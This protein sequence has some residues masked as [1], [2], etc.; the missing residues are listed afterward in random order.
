MVVQLLVRLLVL[1]LFELLLVDVVGGSRASEEINLLILSGNDSLFLQG[2]HRNFVE[3]G[4][5]A[6]ESFFAR[7]NRHHREVAAEFDDEL[8]LEV[9]VV[10]VEFGD[11]GKDLAE[12]FCSEVTSKPVL[13]LLLKGPESASLATTSKVV[14]TI[15]KGSLHLAQRLMIHRHLSV[16]R[17]LS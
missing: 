8:V 1:H 14:Q 6:L 16:L 5:C 3:R 2:G 4:D 9:P 10:V 15:I 7:V 12:V 13:E 17:A 11:D